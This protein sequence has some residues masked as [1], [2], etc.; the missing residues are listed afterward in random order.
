[1]PGRSE[2]STIS[3]PRNG[4]CTGSGRVDLPALLL[5]LAVV[6]LLVPGRLLFLVFVLVLLL[7]A[8][9]RVVGARHHLGA[10][11]E[12]GVLGRVALGVRVAGRLTRRGIRLLGGRVLVHVAEGQRTGDQAERDTEDTELL[13]GF[14]GHHLAPPSFMK[15][16]GGSGMACPAGDRRLSGRPV[17]DEG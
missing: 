9:G 5:I 8:G 11:T 2:G 13:E 1:M 3:R 15:I 7:A 16:E 14:L 17:T 6:A 12:A 4:M 10:V